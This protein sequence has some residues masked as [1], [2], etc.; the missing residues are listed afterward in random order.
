MHYHLA[1]IMF[2][3]VCSTNIQQL[4]KPSGL[5]EG[6]YLEA[7]FLPSCFS[8]WFECSA[9]RDSKVKHVNGWNS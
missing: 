5:L 1:V 6:A 2:P 7:T 3:E 4:T 9:F 8:L